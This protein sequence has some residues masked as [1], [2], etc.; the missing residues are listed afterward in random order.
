MME[1]LADKRIPRFDKEFKV[2][3]RYGHPPSE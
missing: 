3:F 1:G 2:N